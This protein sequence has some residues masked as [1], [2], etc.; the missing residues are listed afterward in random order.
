M[1]HIRKKDKVLIL[2]GK[3]RGKT[4]EVLKVL[5]DKKK[6][7][8]S[9]INM[10]F[11]HARPTQNNPGGIN[12]QESPMDVSNVALICTKCDKPTK[13]QMKKLETGEKVRICKKCNGDII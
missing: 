7:S 6:V 9:G 2:A 3:D 4:G 5:V 13:A 10:V 8:V 11:K 12:K 1:L